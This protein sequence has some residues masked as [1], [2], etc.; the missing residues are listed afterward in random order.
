MLVRKR[1]YRRYGAVPLM[2]SLLNVKGKAISS[3]SMNPPSARVSLATLSIL[4]WVDGPVD[5][6]M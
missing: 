6:A 5:S 4:A 1:E 3:T 2:A